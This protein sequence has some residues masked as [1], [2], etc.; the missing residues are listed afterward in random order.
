[1][2]AT[3]SSGAAEQIEPTAAESTGDAFSAT[4]GSAIL[5]RT[6]AWIEAFAKL[7]LVALIGNW[8]LKVLGY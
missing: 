5:F 2:S 8:V 1:L 4:T 6:P 7:L 3:D